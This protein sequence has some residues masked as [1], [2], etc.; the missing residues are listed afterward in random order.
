MLEA[1]DGFESDSREEGGA[2]SNAGKSLS[3]TWRCVSEGIV[4]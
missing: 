3:N 2:G 1:R 4:K